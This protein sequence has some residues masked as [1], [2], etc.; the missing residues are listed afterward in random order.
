[1]K[2]PYVVFGTS[3]VGVFLH[4]FYPRRSCQREFQRASSVCRWRRPLPVGTV[5]LYFVLSRKGGS[6]RFCCFCCLLFF[7]FPP[8]S[9][10]WNWLYSGVWYQQPQVSRG[11]VTFY[12]PY[13]CHLC[14]GVEGRVGVGGRVC[15]VGMLL[16]WVV[17][18]SAVDYR[19]VLLRCCF[20]EPRGVRT[21]VC[22][23]LT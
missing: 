10:T 18:R 12:R 19:I 2:C 21:T 1:M 9:S 23:F 16:Y 3:R 15:V 7:C 5:E 20:S 8:L 14:L 13:N 11:Q 22:H 6:I 17:Q 4:A